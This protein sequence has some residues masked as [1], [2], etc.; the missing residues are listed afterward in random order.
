MECDKIFRPLSCGNAARLGRG[1][2]QGAVAGFPLQTIRPETAATDDGTDRRR[3]CALRRACRQ[4]SSGALFTAA[5]PQNRKADCRD[6]LE[7]LFVAKGRYRSEG[8]RS[9]CDGRFP[10]LRRDDFRRPSLQSMDGCKRM[11][12]PSGAGSD[13]A[14]NRARRPPANGHDALPENARV[15]R[16][17]PVAAAAAAG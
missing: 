2:A 4:Q 13:Y 12:V 10:P 15:R 9:G 14:R 1:T 16:M 5:S 11:A 17:A 3:P 6:R 8:R 7:R